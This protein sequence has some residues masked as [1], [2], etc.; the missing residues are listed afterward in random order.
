[1]L[2]Q[3]CS[4]CHMFALQLDGHASTQQEKTAA[5]RLKW[6]TPEHIEAV[7]KLT[8]SGCYIHSFMENYERKMRQKQEQEH[9][10]AE[11]SC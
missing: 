8:Q 1:M 9:G 7:K 3:R 10:I 6:T 2:S 5:K 4:Q 11:L